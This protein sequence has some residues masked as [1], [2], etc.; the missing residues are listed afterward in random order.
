LPDWQ[1]R[2]LRNRTG[3]KQGD[4]HAFAASILA[5]YAR[6]TGYENVSLGGKGGFAED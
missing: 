5:R 6:D 1:R 4:G 2:E 3:R